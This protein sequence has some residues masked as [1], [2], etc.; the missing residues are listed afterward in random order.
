[1]LNLF[2]RKGTCLCTWKD[3]GFILFVPGAVINYWRV[4][5][6]VL[7]PK[8]MVKCC[9]PSEVVIIWLPLP[10]DVTTV[11]VAVFPFTV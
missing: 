4:N 9:Q 7:E 2:V 10:S 5:V 11:N 8:T 1:M 3:P 6:T